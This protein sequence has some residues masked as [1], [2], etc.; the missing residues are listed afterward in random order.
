M[1]LS[2]FFDQAPLQIGFR[3]DP[4]RTRGALAANE[5]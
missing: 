3:S 5:V 4:E 1:S 2:L